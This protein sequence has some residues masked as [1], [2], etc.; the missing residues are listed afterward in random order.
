MKR[1]SK[2]RDA[3]LAAVK[4]VRTHPTAAQIYDDV[5]EVIPNISL[6]TVYRNL[7]E[8]KTNGDIIG[9]ESPDGAEHF[10]G[11]T[12]GHWHFCCLGCKKIFD[13]KKYDVFGN[14]ELL[15]ELGEMKLDVK[16]AEVMLYGYCDLCKQQGL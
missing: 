12:D 11:N 15:T 14:P 8:L 2:Q 5:R 7:A 3:V 13:L 10:D 4:A 6:G 9:F 1:N 16:F